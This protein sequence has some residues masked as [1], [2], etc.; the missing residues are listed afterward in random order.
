[1]IYYQVEVSKGSDS[2]F[3]KEFENLQRAN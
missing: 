3:L 2:E 1:L